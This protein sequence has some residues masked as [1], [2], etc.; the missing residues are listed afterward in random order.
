MNSVLGIAITIAISALAATWL[1]S[2]LIHI[3]RRRGV[4]D[5]PNHR[6]SH[7]QPTPRGGGAAI[8]LVA[9]ASEAILGVAGYLDLRSALALGIGGLLIAAVG[10]W[11]D[12]RSLPAGVR[13]AVQFVA[14]LI[15][16]AALSRTSAIS[17]GDARLT[18]S[19]PT[20]VVAVLA[21]VWL[22][23][24]YNFMDGTDGIAGIEGVVAG[25]SASLLLF[26][27]G[28]HGLAL[29]AASIAGASSGFLVFNWTP[30]RIFMGDVGSGFLGFTFAVLAV[31]SDRPA[32]VAAVWI[33]LP[34]LPFV[35]DSTATLIR[36]AVRGAPLASA[37]REHLYQR[38]VREG[39]SHAPVA[40]AF[41]T[42]STI[43][44]GIAAV[45]FTYQAQF[46]AILSAAVV[47]SAAAYLLISD[48]VPRRNEVPL[49]SG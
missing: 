17:L 49:S 45:A 47:L 44:A 29:L 1:T 42:A 15:A 10:A 21:T 28:Q 25:L 2:R 32:G 3:T 40:V 6:S 12:L 41:G 27:A 4:I 36:R 34:L 30:A 5:V 43:L 38:L 19:G 16:M 23:N 37:H 46:W 7:V 14:A 48:V 18:L 9:L 33:A 24:L 35:V 13:L 11:D 8:V 26:L 22:T 39:R 20:F 31:A